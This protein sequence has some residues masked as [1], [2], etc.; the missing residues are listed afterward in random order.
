[1]DV[2]RTITAYFATAYD[3]SEVAGNLRP[4]FEVEGPRHVTPVNGRAY[5]IVIVIPEGMSPMIMFPDSHLMSRIH[6]LVMAHD[7][8]TT[9]PAGA[10]S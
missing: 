8:L 9:T 10:P 2:R 5:E 4:Q 1:M 3:A 7:G 6:N